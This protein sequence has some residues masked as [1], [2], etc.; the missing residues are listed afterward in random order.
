MIAPMMNSLRS[1]HRPYSL[2]VAALALA[3][4]SVAH[5]QEPVHRTGTW[6]ADSFGNHRAVVSV[7]L[8]APA[9]WAHLPW[10]RPDLHPEAKAVWVVDAK[11]GHR[12]LNV[13]RGSITREFGD[14]AFEPTSGPGEYYVYFLRYA[15]SVTSNYP[16]L[17]YPGPDSTA[18]STWLS[19]FDPRQ[20][21]RLPAARVIAFEAADTLDSFY[22]MQ[23]IATAD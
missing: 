21:T 3:L 17:T 9:V 2:P 7:S 11:T 13:A 14:I 8:A 12:V 16:K 6:V 20:L 5:A 15:G 18:S 19:L 10:R 4:A 23:V 1:C 22:P